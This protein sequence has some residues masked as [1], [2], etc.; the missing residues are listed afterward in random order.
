MNIDG[1]FMVEIMVLVLDNFPIKR[2]TV[3]I[4]CANTVTH[5]CIMNPTFSEL[6]T[7]FPG[8]F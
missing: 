5:K 6:Q 8:S 3:L 1:P 4:I 7:W 2:Q